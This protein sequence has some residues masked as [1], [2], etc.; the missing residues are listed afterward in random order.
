MVGGPAPLSNIRTRKLKMPTRGRFAR[1]NSAS[2]AYDDNVANYV[3]SE[4]AIDYSATAVVLLAALA[5]L[6]AC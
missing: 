6:S 5:R 2:A 1:F 4:P 3:T